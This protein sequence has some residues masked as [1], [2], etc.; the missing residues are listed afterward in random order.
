M[1]TRRPVGFAV[2]AAV[3]VL[4]P[5]DWVLAQTNPA[6]ASHALAEQMFD[7]DEDGPRADIGAS[8]GMPL[9]CL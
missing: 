6:P 5:V 7:A 8:R 1:S 4:A 2:A 3:L 9:P